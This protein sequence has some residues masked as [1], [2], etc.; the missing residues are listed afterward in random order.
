MSKQQENSGKEVSSV[1][2]NK[3]SIKVSFCDGTAVSLDINSYINED[4]FYK[5]KVISLDAYNKLLELQDDS[6]L[7][8]YVLKITSTRLYSSKKIIEK[9]ITVK[10]A[11]Q[12]KAEEVV[13]K[14]RQ[15]GLINDNIYIE[16]YIVDAKNK[17]YSDSKILATLLSDSYER[18]KIE[19]VML[20]YV[21]S[22]EEKMQLIKNL[23]DKYC[24]KNYISCKESVFSSLYKKGYDSETCRKLIDEYLAQNPDVESSFRDRDVLLLKNDMKKYIERYN[25]TEKDE[26][27][28][29]SKVFNV[30]LA[31][32]YDFNDI[33]K[34]WE[35]NK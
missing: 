31:H 15:D 14:L 9:L 33:I 21:S 16:T 22:S 27:C 32:N 25:Q 17:G 2:Y 1:K 34:V 24:N 23:F 10:K 7:Y 12:K 28:L 19:E 11:T 13:Y 3:K 8:S 29:R 35:E 30:L 5:G 6:Q 18:N 4:R 26:Y 20:T